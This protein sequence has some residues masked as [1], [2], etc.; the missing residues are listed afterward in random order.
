MNL[1]YRGRKTHGNLG[2]YA[3]VETAS[4]TRILEFLA[5]MYKRI[6]LQISKTFSY[7]HKKITAKF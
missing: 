4:Y 6:L 3:T 7:W 1:K 2:K 5:Y